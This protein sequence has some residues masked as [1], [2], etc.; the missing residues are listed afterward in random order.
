MVVNEETYQNVEQL[1]LLKYAFYE[2][3]GCVQEIFTKLKH[4]SFFLQFQNYNLKCFVFFFNY[5][6]TIFNHLC[7]KWFS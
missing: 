7:S 6:M 1:L 4:F 3:H 2:S 5:C